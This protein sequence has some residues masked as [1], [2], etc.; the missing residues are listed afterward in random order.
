M[1]SSSSTKPTRQVC[2]V[3]AAADSVLISRGSTDVVSLHTCGKA[4]G[5]SG[6]LVLLPAVMRDFLVNRARAFIYA[7]APSPLMAA[8]VRGA[9]GLVQSQPERRE[10]HARLVAMPTVRSRPVVA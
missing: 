1:A 6:A 3:L 7:T 5:A 8:A 4:L 2:S 10:R 9:L